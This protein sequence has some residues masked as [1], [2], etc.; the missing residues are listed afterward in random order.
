M[1]KVEISYETKLVALSLRLSMLYVWH[2]AI[3]PNM[4][5]DRSKISDLLLDVLLTL[6]FWGDEKM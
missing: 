1:S 4:F 6:R 5:G 3:V 2:Y